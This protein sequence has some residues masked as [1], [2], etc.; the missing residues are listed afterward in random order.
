MLSKSWRQ[1]AGSLM[2]LGAAGQAAGQSRQRL[3]RLR[4]LA[5][6]CRAGSLADG[7]RGAALCRVADGHHVL[8]LQVGRGA[9]TA[10]LQTLQECEDPSY[11]ICLRQTGGER[12][13]LCCCRLRK[14]HVRRQAPSHS[15][16]V[17][18]AM[19]SRAAHV[20]MLGVQAAR[21]LV[22]SVSR[23]SRS[24]GS[25]RRTVLLDAGLALR[26]GQS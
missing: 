17:C 2:L 9:G 11:R 23:C 16:L 21:Q 22:V 12:L 10:P 18:Q 1:L 8:I 5:R 20:P 13:V 3:H 15:S 19:E 24:L 14:R 7:V 6:G 4:V 26:M 25:Q